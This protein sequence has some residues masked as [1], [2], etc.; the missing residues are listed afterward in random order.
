MPSNLTDGRVTIDNLTSTER[1][2]FEAIKNAFLVQKAALYGDRVA[3][4]MTQPLLEDLARDAR[5]FHHLVTGDCSEVDPEDREVM[6]RITKDV[7]EG[8]EF[9]VRS[10]EFSDEARRRQLAEEYLNSLKP[11]QRIAFER[12]GTLEDK[13]AFYV[14]EQLDARFVCSE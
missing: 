13:T 5:V 10:I 4:I 9:A 3:D 12:D 14:A 11:T 8:N 6:R 7:I 2:R 1:M